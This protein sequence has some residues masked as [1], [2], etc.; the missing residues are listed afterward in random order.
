MYSLRNPIH[1]FS[2][3]LSHCKNAK[4]KIQSGKKYLEGIHFLASDSHKNV[5]KFYFIDSTP[6]A[7]IFLEKKK[8]KNSKN[9]FFGKS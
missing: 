1:P 3:F 8:L 4:I 6:T 9:V 2:K 5:L 7:L